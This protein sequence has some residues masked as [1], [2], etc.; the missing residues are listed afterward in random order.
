MA[1]LQAGRRRV[2]VF[3]EGQLTRRAPRAAAAITNT[4]VCHR[5]HM[6]NCF[7]APLVVKKRDDFFEAMD[8]QVQGSAADR[9]VGGWDAAQRQ[10]GG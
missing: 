5:L 8:T 3:R 4:F 2:Q 9:F 10:C 1:R 6:R 7:V